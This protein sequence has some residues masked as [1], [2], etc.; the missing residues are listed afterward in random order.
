MSL[1]GKEISGQCGMALLA[2]VSQIFRK[3]LEHKG[4]EWKNLE[5]YCLAR[6]G[7]WI[8]VLKRLGP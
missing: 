4:I 6:K 8:K 2:A 7:T 5:T 1:S 3:N